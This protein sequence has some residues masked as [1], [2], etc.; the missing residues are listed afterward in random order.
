MPV[1]ANVSQRQPKQTFMSADRLFAYPAVTLVQTLVTP[2]STRL[3]SYPDYL[4]QP[5]TP[6]NPTPTSPSPIVRA[7]LQSSP[8]SFTSLCVVHHHHG[9][10]LCYVVLEAHTGAP[11]P[12]R[13]GVHD[14][15][16]RRQT[17]ANEGQP[18]NSPKCLEDE[19]EE[20]G[21]EGDPISTVKPWRR[22]RRRR[23]RRSC[24]WRSHRCSGSACYR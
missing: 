17:L 5:A 23:S 22:Q 12:N 6:Q 9:P 10:I 1:R 18:P 24:R 4:C 20:D 11:R 7:A 3:S 16:A 2:H 13:G 15:E 21:E 19:M 8:H 14:A